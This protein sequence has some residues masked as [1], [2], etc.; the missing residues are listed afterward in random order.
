MDVSHKI[1]RIWSKKKKKNLNIS[2]R[3]KEMS[4]GSDFESSASDE[5]ARLCFKKGF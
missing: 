5:G 3:S 1:G 2:L 4:E